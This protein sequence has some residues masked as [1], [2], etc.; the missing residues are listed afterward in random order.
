MG[1][2]GA[3]REVPSG[4]RMLGRRYSEAE[5]LPKWNDNVKKPLRGERKIQIN[6]CRS[7]VLCYF[8][9]VNKRSSNHNNK[10]KEKAKE[11]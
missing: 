1:F 10:T 4:R 2:H 5:P 3:G 8:C 11:L 7:Y 9:S 6:A